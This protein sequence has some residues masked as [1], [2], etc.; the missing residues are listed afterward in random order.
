[1]KSALQVHVL[2][3]SGKRIAGYQG[4]CLEAVSATNFSL[5]SCTCINSM[6]TCPPESTAVSLCLLSS[7]RTS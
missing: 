5:V 1:M 7:R 3:I 2:A 6:Y 4:G